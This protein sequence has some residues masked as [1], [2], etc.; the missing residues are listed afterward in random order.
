MNNVVFNAK[1]VFFGSLT[2]ASGE[3]F[4][5]T[6]SSQPP[7]FSFNL[8]FSTSSSIERGDFGSIFDPK[9]PL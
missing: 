6:L 2:S 1:F 3:L 5:L 4:Y 9:S 8:V 7:P